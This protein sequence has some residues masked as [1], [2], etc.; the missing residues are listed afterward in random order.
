V[1]FYLAIREKLAADFPAVPAYRSNLASSHNNLG[2]LLAGLGKG[3]V[4]QQQYRK[5]LAIREKLAADF[6][7]VPGYRVELG[8]S[9][10]NFGDL[11]ARGGKL[12]D[13]LVWF[14]KAIATLRPVHEQEPRAVIAKVFLRNSHWGRAIAHHRLGQYAEAV[15]DWDRAIA[16]SEIPQQPA[17][18]ARRANSQV[19]AGQ[20]AEAVAEVAAL[21]APCPDGTG[22]ARWNA[23]QWYNFACI[24]SLASGKIADRKQE[25]ADRAMELLRKAVKAGYKNASHMKKDTDLDP[26]RDRADF[27]TLLGELEQ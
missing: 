24:Y 8:A 4:A 25:Y 16:L 14:Q 9:Y 11:M 23:G 21:T 18:R 20:V 6:P 2:L 10:C 1:C 22:L 3:A 12:A 17:L 27:K 19:R 13:S 26:L 5:A 7:A 15:K